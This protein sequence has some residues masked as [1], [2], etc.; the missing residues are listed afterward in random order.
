MPP[1]QNEESPVKHIAKGFVCLRWVFLELFKKKGLSNLKRITVV[2]DVCMCVSNQW[3]YVDNY[4]DAVNQL[5][6]LSSSSVFQITAVHPAPAPAR[7]PLPAH[8]TV[9]KHL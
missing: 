2:Q 6:I 3:A 9:L 8:W 4:A 5:L 1:H 7:R